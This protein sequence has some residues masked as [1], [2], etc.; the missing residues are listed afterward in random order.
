[1]FFS[2]LPILSFK[3]FRFDEVERG[4][5]NLPASSSQNK[6]YIFFMFFSLLPILSFKAFR[7]D[8]VERGSKNF[9]DI[10]L[11]KHHPTKNYIDRLRSPLPHYFLLITIYKYIYCFKIIWI[12]LH[13]NAL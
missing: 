1:M 7:F 11:I 2:L 6:Q 12:R 4:S 9:L 10:A 13:C 3:A 5:K 8:V